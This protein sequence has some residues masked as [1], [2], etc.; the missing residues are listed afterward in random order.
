MRHEQQG[1]AG[2]A[3]LILQLL[4]H[5]HVQVVGRLVQDQ[6]IGCVDQHLGHGEALLLT[7]A[8][9]VHRLLHVAQAE[10][11]QQHLHMG[12][13]VPRVQLGHLVDGAAAWLA[14]STWRATACS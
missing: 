2:C 3:Q 8:Q 9:G 11:V 4:D 14:S 10:T 1:E 6:H 5:V 7:T 12:L 13:V